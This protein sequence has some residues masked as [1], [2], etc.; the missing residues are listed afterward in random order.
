MVILF[1]RTEEKHITLYIIW[2]RKNADIRE[3]DGTISLVA[4]DQTH[5]FT[6]YD[7]IRTVELFFPYRQNHVMCNV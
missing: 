5:V 6:L 4:C 2:S 1:S 3:P 7:F